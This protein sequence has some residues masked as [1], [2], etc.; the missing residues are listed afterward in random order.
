M[1]DAIRAGVSIVVALLLL[2]GPA[3][4]VGL[5][6]CLGFLVGFAC[7]LGVIAYGL[8]QDRQDG[9]PVDPSDW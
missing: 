9:A 4:L 3:F 1:R 6:Y 2:V 8:E 7:A 5:G